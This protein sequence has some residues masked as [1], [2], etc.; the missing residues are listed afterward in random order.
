M[1]KVKI[2]KK[3]CKGCQL[4]VV[5]CPRK[6]LALDKTLA[7]SGVFPAVVIKE[8]DCSGCG[9]CFVMCPDVAIEIEG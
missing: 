1:A 8:D 4:C 9:L 5:V 6:N 7:E 2:N 3:R